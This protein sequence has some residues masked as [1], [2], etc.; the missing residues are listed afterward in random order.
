MINVGYGDL[1]HSPVIIPYNL[2]I[3]WWLIVTL[4]DNEP[5]WLKLYVGPVI[6]PNILKTVFSLMNFW[7]SLPGDYRVTDVA[8]LAE[9][10]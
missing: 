7:L 1:F 5:V 8:L 10:T 2:K 4:W 3:N 9:T 6:L